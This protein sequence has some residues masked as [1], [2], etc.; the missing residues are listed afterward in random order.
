MLRRL[1][2]GMVLLGMIGCEDFQ[3]AMESD[4]GRKSVTAPGIASL[5][6][7]EQ[8]GNAADGNRDASAAASAQQ[9]EAAPQKEA[10]RESERPKKSAT[11]RSKRKVKS[12][13]SK[14]I[15]GRT[16]AKVVDAQKAK[17][18]PKIVEVEN[19]I[20][21]SDPLTVSASAYVAM[22][23][24][25][26]TLGFQQA[27]KMYKALNDRNPSYSEFMDMVKQNRVE[28]AALPPYQM[29][30]Y[31]AQKGGLVILEDKAKKIQLYKKHGIPIE[32]QDKEYE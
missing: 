26:S 6:E 11:K 29:Y 16:T 21:G 5:D 4:S 2:V 1:A 15:L 30:G 27:L 14:S 28:F 24:R 3:K 32:E 17:Q 31:D 13:P 19:K 20:S 18:N 12:P 8:V 9:E 10:K 25:V 23:S 22:A 7:V